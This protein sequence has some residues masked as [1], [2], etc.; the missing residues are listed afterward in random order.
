MIQ[1]N[2]DVQQFV[3][4]SYRI[5]RAAETY[6][7][8]FAFLAVLGLIL[9]VALPPSLEAAPKV[10]KQE[11]SL[12]AETLQPQ[13]D[14]PFS[15]QA[16]IEK[17]EH[18]IQTNPN[19]RGHYLVED[20]AYRVDFTPE[21]ILYYPKEEG[22]SPDP[23]EIFIRME[24]ILSD[25]EESPIHLSG[26][27]AKVVENKVVYQR[28]PAVQEIYEARKEGVEQSW[29]IQH[30]LFRST[31]DLT[32][33][34]EVE[35]SLSPIPSASG[36]I[37]FVDQDGRYVTTYGQVTVIDDEGKRINIRPELKNSV[38]TI[39]IPAHWLSDAVYPLIVDPLI[40]SNLQ[41]DALAGTDSYP[42]IAFD[43]TNYLIVW[44]SGTPDA[45]G[46]GTTAIRAARVSGA[47]ALLDATP[48]TVGDTTGQDDEFPSV[49]YDSANSRYII[50][51]MTWNGTTSADVFMNTVTTAG[52]VGTA[53]NILAGG[54]RI[55]AYPSVAC[56]DVN[57]NYYVVYGES[58]IGATDFTAYSG[59]TYNRNTHAAATAS[60]PAATV[61]SGTIAPDAAPRSAPRL[62]SLSAAK[63]LLVWET[64]GADTE[65]DVAANVVAVT[66]T[67]DYSWGTEASVA[68][69]AATLERVPRAAYDGTNVLFVYQTGASTS[70]DVYGRF[71]DPSGTSLALG[72]SAFA[73][74]A[75]A[76]SGQVN[77]DV[78][79]TGGACSANPVNRY[80]VV[81]QDYRNS[82]V[83]PD[84]YAS[85]VDMSEVV[86]TAVPL[87]TET[88]YAKEYPVIAADG[89]SCA[90][91]GG[92]SDNRNS[93]TTS[94]DIYVQLVGYPNISNLSPLSGA[95]GETISINGLN[96]GSDP[97]AGNRSTAVFNVKIDGNP[98]ADADVLFWSETVVNFSIPAGATPGISSVTVTA[99][100]WESNGVSLTVD[101]LLQ[102]TTVSLAD[103]YQWL[104]YGANVAATGGTGP[105]SWTIISGSLPTGLTLNGGTGLISGT[106]SGFGTFNF[107]VEVTDSRT[108]TPQTATKA[109]SILIHELTTI[110]VTPA[111]PSITPGQTIQFTAM[112]S[113]SDSSQNDLTNIVS[114]NSNDPLVATIDSSGLATGVGLGA[115]TISATK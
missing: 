97:G 53:A 50:V 81:W 79:F 114:W 26:S 101:T 102:I 2:R 46:T 105:Y 39:T 61:S 74:S 87:A 90:F 4:S 93:G 34:G 59:Q 71:G 91:L 6:S 98:I 29:I 78:A 67:P 35:T 84:I 18:S 19:S 56:C 73:V 104:S 82:A 99:G 96:F 36:G 85:P 28:T 38:L 108:P 22:G 83:N 47:G 107:T 49:A 111:N 17:A 80:M 58:G 31:G 7:A 27:T 9:S 48:L 10:E 23:K 43:G 14:V 60:N 33:L 12:P 41:V 1:N 66:T 76:G 75:P 54:S 5:R 103:G 113:Y 55:F 77:P 109:L 21:G 42:A 100:N 64:F 63:Y 16:I 37:D 95:E 110:A 44:Q 3:S 70:A 68:N 72:G 25:S 11:T 69:A 57:D 52:A 30:P 106:P 15:I 8:V 24:S 51:W 62:Y 45:S 89:G 20:P 40:G 94:Y 92:W 86:G 32:I 65:G 88:T 13:A 115:V 112:G